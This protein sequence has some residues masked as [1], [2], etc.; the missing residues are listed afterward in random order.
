MRKLLF[1]CLG[2]LICSP[3]HAVMVMFNP[4][5][6]TYIKG[7]NG[8]NIGANFGSSTQLSADFNSFTRILIRDS[9]IF[10]TVPLGSTIDSA[11]LELDRTNPSIGNISV[12]RV[13]TSWDEGV[14]T[15]DNFNSGGTAGTDYAAAAGT[16]YVPGSTGAADPID[17][18]DITSIVQEWS[19][20]A[21]NEGVILIN[22][23]NDGVLYRSDDD[24]TVGG[25]VPKLTINYSTAV[26]PE[27]SAF[28][29]LGLVACGFGARKVK[30]WKKS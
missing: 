8:L 6:T 14:V 19:N 4:D 2:L 16:V 13:I 24:T 21:A 18:I 27:P 10:P 22:D 9:S 25:A 17:A 1:V 15:W 26:I 5:D 28:L 3:A 29:L 12:H 23:N 11:I 20:G 30:S 7:D